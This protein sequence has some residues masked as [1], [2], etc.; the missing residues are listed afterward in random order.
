MF[1]RTVVNQSPERID[2][3]YHKPSTAQDLQLLRDI[4]RE[5]EREFCE[6]RALDNTIKAQMFRSEETQSVRVCARLNGRD[7]SFS[8]TDQQ[9]WIDRNPQAIV[10]AIA[11]EFAREIMLAVAL[12]SKERP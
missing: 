7:I 5:V 4:R 10:D 3:H 12:K 1:D 9:I 2:H 11:Y 8:V 6:T